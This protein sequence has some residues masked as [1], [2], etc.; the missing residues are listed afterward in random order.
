MKELPI[1]LDMRSREDILCRMQELAASYT[2]EWKFHSRYPDAGSALMNLYS[3]MLLDMIQHYNL[4]PER[5]RLAFFQCLE[6]RQK[7]AEP[8]RGYVSFGITKGVE[9]GT[10]VP[11]GTV[12]LGI[13]EQ[14]EGIRLETRD[15]IF[16]SDGEIKA[17]Y[18]A[19]GSRDWMECMAEGEGPVSNRSHRNIQTHSCI[20]EHST[21]LSGTEDAE[22]QIAFEV[23]DGRRDWDRLLQDREKT[24]F[25][26]CYGQRIWSME[27]RS[28]QDHIIRFRKNN[29]MPI[30]TEPHIQS[31]LQD[32]TGGAVLWKVKDIDTFADLELKGIRLGSSG[33]GLYPEGV[34]T[35]EGEEGIKRYYPFGERPYVYGAFYICSHEVFGKKGAEVK[36]QIHLEFR[37]IPLLMEPVP[38]P[39]HW[40]TIMK[41][42]DFMEE[43]PVPITIGEVVWEYYN[44]TGFTRLYAE[45]LYTD[46]FLPWK[47]EVEGKESVTAGPMETV[48]KKNVEL[49]L[50]CPMD[51]QPVLVNARQTYCIRARILR[52]NHAYARNGYYITPF[53]TQMELSYSY[54]NA[55]QEPE[56]C[57]IQNNL[58]QQRIGRNQTFYP[59]R[60]LEESRPA[61]YIGL[62]KPLREGPYGLYCGVTPKNTLEIPEKWNY[63]YYNG[64]E[65]KSLMLEDHTENLRKNGTFLL[66]GNEDIANRQL[67][68][69][70]CY[71][72]RMVLVDGS[73]E[74]GNQQHR[75]LPIRELWWNTVPIQAVEAVPE[76]YFTVDAYEEYPVCQLK[77]RNIYE[78]EVWGMEQEGITEHWI[79]WEE[80]EDIRASTAQDRHYQID[81]REG[82][83]QL[84]NRIRGRLSEHGTN[85]KAVCTVNCGRKGNLQAGQVK[86]LTRS[87]RF[88]QQVV[89][90]APL[91]GGRDSEEEEEAVTRVCQGLLHQ[92]RAVMASD[93]EALAQDAS[94]EVVRVKA[95]PNRNPEGKQ[96]RG[97]I[98]LVILSE[99]YRAEASGFEALRECVWDFIQT[100][101]P[102]VHAVRQHFFIIEPWFTEI[103]V[104][105]VCTLKPHASLFSCRAEM[106][107]Q[108]KNF[109]DPMTGNFDKKGWEIGKAPRREQIRN[110]LRRVRQV[111]AVRKLVVKAYCKRNHE[112][113]EINL[114]GTIPEYLVVING[115]HHIRLELP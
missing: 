63:E 79:R 30:V 78:I 92:N 15:D 40:K 51:I 72:I 17:V 39:V 18:Y 11:R 47:D 76:E 20:L 99:N 53:H 61:I 94:R 41:Q 9:E 64:K 25:F 95:Y 98:T 89:N 87:I 22:L 31:S 70:E 55:M 105:V 23:Q 43:E 12:L 85:V 35:A 28:C 91:T 68:G 83:I 82:R 86:Q 80:V 50:T 74:T 109:L 93:Y 26:Y 81:R 102:E 101:M 7:P 3:D 42:S 33:T 112:L 19:D 96:E 90:R 52:M 107:E 45:P 69:K 84:S 71:W 46:V 10:K 57:M 54:E 62:S 37:K 77:Q 44:G 34:Y 14:G 65:W 58:K 36:L 111:E 32:R 5:D 113:Q 49:K 73:M 27:A 4:A 88:I 66:F 56:C 106:E 21:V 115:T 97:T 114:E 110:V 29:E 1:Q 13:N 103:Q 2:P 8:A 108:L 48:M 100:R 24:E 6:T 38:V 60:K 75:R 104:S 59:F 67:F 16:V